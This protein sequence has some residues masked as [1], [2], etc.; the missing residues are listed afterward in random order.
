MTDFSL[1]FMALIVGFFHSFEADHLA[2]VSNLVSTKKSA[3][4]SLKDGMFWGIGHTVTIFFI[5]VLILVLKY[6]ISEN[7]FS[8]FEGLVG[9]MLIVLGIYRLSKLKQV[10]QTLHHGHNHKLALGVGLIHGIAGSG[11]VV[12][13]AVSATSTISIGLLYLTIFGM[14]SILG[15]LCVAFILGKI[16]YLKKLEN[17]NIVSY[18]SIFSS[19]FCIVFGLK[20]FIYNFT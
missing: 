2:A 11:A 3:I 20:I 1:I 19:L 16:L 14:G 13:A 5:G 8:K 7:V 15:M 6:S 10:K 12:A 4:Q 9:I 18:F 17:I